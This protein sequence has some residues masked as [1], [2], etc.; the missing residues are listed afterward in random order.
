MIALDSTVCPIKLASE[1]EEEQGEKHL[2]SV[3]RGREKEGE[4]ES[5]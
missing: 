5:E 2:S 4:A 1:Q 3:V